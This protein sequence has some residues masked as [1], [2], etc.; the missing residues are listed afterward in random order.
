MG[1]NFLGG[2]TLW[3]EQF[4]RGEHFLGGE[5]FQEEERFLEHTFPMENT[6]GRTLFFLLKTLRFEEVRARVPTVHPQPYL[7][8]AKI[9]T[10]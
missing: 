7:H 10:M 3:G 1:G 8:V 4:L 9:K 6:L 2:R 5:H